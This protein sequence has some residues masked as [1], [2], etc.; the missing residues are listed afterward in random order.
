VIADMAKQALGRE[1]YTGDLTADHETYL[2]GHGKSPGRWC[3]HDAT[4][5]GL[6]G[7]AS[8]TG[9]DR[10][11]CSWRRDSN[12]EPAAYKRRWPHMLGDGGHCLTKSHFYSTTT[13]ALRAARRAFTA[14]RHCRSADQLD[15]DGRIL[16]PVGMVAVASW[17]YTGRGYKTPPTPSSPSP[18]APPTSTHA[19]SAARS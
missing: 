10:R 1:D 4:S 6:Q 2:S 5:L 13:A 7:E 17:H 11:C 3:G 19:A 15:P 9:S 18:F 12:P 16:P 8:V 14:R